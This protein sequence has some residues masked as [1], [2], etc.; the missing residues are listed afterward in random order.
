MFNYLKK[1]VMDMLAVRQVRAVIGENE[2]MRQVLLSV[3]EGLHNEPDENTEPYL[4]YL[5]TAEEEERRL[6][7]SELSQKLNEIAES[8]DQKHANRQWLLHTAQL[9]A[10]LKILFISK[11]DE[12][13]ERWQHPCLFGMQNHI[14]EILELKYKD[15]VDNLGG[16][17]DASE[18]LRIESLRLHLLM[19]L[20]LMVLRHLK[21]TESDWFPAL[22]SSMMA[23]E[24]VQLRKSL[25]LK[26]PCDHIK[27]RNEEAM[28]MLN[29]VNMEED[30][31]KNVRKAK[32]FD[33]WEMSRDA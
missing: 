5:Q 27:I 1:K 2:W 11:P 29:A 18:Y 13:G 25:G 8:K 21:D 28:L 19:N 10:P 4:V 20:S 32:I 7:A 23:N 3:A 22:F 14:R 33:D 17:Y 12:L 26:I 24:E 9:Y 16:L 31:F 30:I 6:F 15:E